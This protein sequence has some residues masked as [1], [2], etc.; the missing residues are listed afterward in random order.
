VN[1][2]RG[3]SEVEMKAIRVWAKRNYGE[4]TEKPL[5]INSLPAT[6]F[7]EHP[8]KEIRLDNKMR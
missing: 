2:W 1:P 7:N 8:A 4:P 6:F 3:I 5:T